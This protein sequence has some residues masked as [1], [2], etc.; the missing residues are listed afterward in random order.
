M[1]QQRKMKVGP[2]EGTCVKAHLLAFPSACTIFLAPL[3]T[4]HRFWP[5]P[6]LPQSAYPNLQG[7]FPKNIFGSQKK[8]KFLST[9]SP[10]PFFSSFLNFI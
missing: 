4:L 2:R 6:S 10:P 3:L 9:P 1:I 7:S 5:D 8:K